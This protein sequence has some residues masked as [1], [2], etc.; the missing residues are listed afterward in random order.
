MDSTCSHITHS[1]LYVEHII[2]AKDL[3]NLSKKEE[4]LSKQIKP[5]TVS[6]VAK[7]KKLFKRGK[8]WML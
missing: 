5:E 1:N 8:K 2:I 4:E 3:Y 7:I 6:F